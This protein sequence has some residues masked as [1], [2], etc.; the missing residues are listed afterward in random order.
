MQTARYASAGAGQLQIC[1]WEPE[2]EAIGVVQLVHGIAE[3]LGRYARFA[4]TLSRAGYLV[5]GEEHMGH[6]GSEGTPRLHFVGGWQ[7]AVEDV[8]GLYARVHGARPELPYY[9]FGHS[10]GSF[11]TRSLL[12]VHPELELHG[13]VLCGTGWLSASV[14]A[15]G[16]AL[17]AL[18]IRRRG[19]EGFSPLVE[20]LMFGAYNRKFRPNRTPNDWICS[21]PEAVDC[22]TADP[23]CGGQ[24]TLGLSRDMLRGMTQNQKRKNLARM[25]NALPVHFIAG[26]DDPVGNMGRGVTRTADAFRRAGMQQVSMRLFDGRHEILQEPNA[27]QVQED[28]L[29]F[30]SKTR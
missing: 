1:Y 14:L 20:S 25:Q 27:A 15:A 11:L 8:Y 4:Q 22:Y 19:A 29:E 2:G 18:A 16:R 9:I 23:L 3:H 5:V 24:V 10:M 17:C 30:L 26:R 6:G 28:V 7:A 12:Y 21:S 13:V